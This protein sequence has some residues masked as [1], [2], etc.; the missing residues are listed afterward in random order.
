MAGRH[1]EAQA[2]SKTGLFSCRD[3]LDLGAVFLDSA[4]KGVEI[5][6]ARNLE[7]GVVHPRHIRW[8]QNHAVA[9]KLVPGTQVDAAIS[10]AADLVQPNAID[11]ML[12]RRIQISH[13]DLNV[14]GSQH[15]LERHDSLPLILNWGLVRPRMNLKCEFR[16]RFRSTPQQRSGSY[17]P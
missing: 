8:A 7:P 10:L 11:I 12:E 1:D 5:G 2:T 9:V 17:W 14:A 6:I 15:T 4:G 3:F 16:Q 13:P